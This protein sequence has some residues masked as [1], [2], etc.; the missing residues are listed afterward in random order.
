MDASQPLVT[1]EVCIDSLASAKIAAANGATRV[2]LNAGLEL[3]GLTPSIGLVE[4]VIEACKPMGCEVIAMVRPRPGGFAYN[5][6]ELVVMQRDIV[7]LLAIGVDGVALGVLTS[8]GDIDDA[9]NR[10]LIQPIL[11]A[12]KQ[13]VFHRAFDLTPNPSSAL[14]TLILLGFHRILTSGQA[15][16]AI[17]GAAVIRALIHQADGRIELLP[18]SGI[19]AKNVEAVIRETGCDQVHASLRQAIQDCSGSSNS[20]IQFDSPPPCDGGFYQ[21]DP[22]KIAAIISAMRV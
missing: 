13:A 6:D 4:Q 7:R 14:E 3:G 18:G 19:K 16:T 22:D 21:A 5:A 2:E 20:A 15:P 12:T 17:Q 9:A 1:L 11:D 8:D 10:A